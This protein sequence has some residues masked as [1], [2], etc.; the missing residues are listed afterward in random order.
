MKKIYLCEKS[1]HN[2][3][4]I[5]CSHVFQMESII[6]SRV[7]KEKKNYDLANK[8]IKLSDERLKS[9]IGKLIG[10]HGIN[11]KVILTRKRIE[12]YWKDLKKN[13]FNKGD[14]FAICKE[15]LFDEKE[16]KLFLSWGK[17]HGYQVIMCE[18]IS[19]GILCKYVV[20]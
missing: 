5:L 9:T 15:E 19:E 16:I 18:E 11:F 8:D 20:K 13:D 4:T 10:Q 2:N 1:F 17:K 6:K 12:K 14:D 7:A 3:I